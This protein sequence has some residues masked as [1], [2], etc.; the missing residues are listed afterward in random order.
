MNLPLIKGHFPQADALE[1]LTQFF[2]IKIKYHENRIDKAHN[3]E[4]IKMRERRIKQLQNDL[5]DAR[6]E[7]LTKG[8]YCELYAE[9]II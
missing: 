2:Q 4:D 5:H 1:L 3:E 7:L 6:H 9:I 8:S